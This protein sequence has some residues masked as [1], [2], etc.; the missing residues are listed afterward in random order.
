M[1]IDNCITQDEIDIALR[2][3]KEIGSMYES[4]GDT[5]NDGY[6]SATFAHKYIQETFSRKTH[7]DNKQLYL[8]EKKQPYLFNDK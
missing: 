6:L 8:F 1:T 7:N 3:L 2:E 4:Y 5:N